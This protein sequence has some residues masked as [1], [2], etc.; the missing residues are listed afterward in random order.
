[1]PKFRKKPIVIEAV[2]FHGQPVTGVC[3]GEN[4][5]GNG[6]KDDPAHI[7]TLEG[8]MSVNYGDWVI[9]GVIGEF[10][11]CKPD[12]FEATYEEVK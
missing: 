5:K 2:H 10:Y 11:A 4:C 9:K 12:V 7:H 6:Y 8:E 3:R 1:M